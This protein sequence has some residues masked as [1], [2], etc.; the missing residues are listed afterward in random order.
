MSDTLTAESINTNRENG[1][2]ALPEDALAEFVREQA[3]L[4]CDLSTSAPEGADI[5]EWEHI[6]R[7]DVEYAEYDDGDVMVAF[8]S[9]TTLQ[10]RTA[11]ATRH[12]PA[13]YAH[14]PADVLI[15]VVW[16]LDPE[17][18]PDVHIEVVPE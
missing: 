5:D 11:R 1:L 2:V 4:D 16:D 13:E 3:K 14:D 8:E 15:S 6:D 18:C 17:A 10:R 9:E 12:H 7:A